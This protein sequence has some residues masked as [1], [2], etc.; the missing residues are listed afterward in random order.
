MKP[1]G[2]HSTPLHIPDSAEG[3]GPGWLHQAVSRRVPDLPPIE[4][5]R[6]E[7]IGADA[8]II[9]QLVRCHLDYGGESRGAPSTVIVK[10]PS[11]SASS[12]RMS[13]RFALY[14][15]EHLFYA[16]VADRVPVR[17]PDVFHADFDPRGQRFVLVLED[18]GG[19]PVVDEIEGANPL[20]AR[21][22]VRALARL[23]GRFWNRTGEPELAGA[24]DGTAR[25]LRST[26][27]VAYLAYLVRTL[28]TFGDAFTTTTR[29]IAEAYGPCVAY[30]M[31]VLGEPPRT[32]AHGDC[33]LDNLFFPRDDGG[34]LAFVDWQVSGKNSGLYDV[35]YFLGSGI[36]TDLR[37][38]IERDLV[39]EYHAGL[40][41]SGVSDLTF[42]ECWR[43]YRLNSFGRLLTMVLVCGGID[44][45]DERTRHLADLGL[46]R[47]LAQVED[48]DAEEFLPTRRRLFS[49]G[50]L[51]SR[52]SRM[53]Y[54]AAQ[55]R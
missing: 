44:L 33:R 3:I 51:F 31:A 12:R 15:R 23:H 5:I 47:S 39:A 40:V 8:G 37:R 52:A 11:L 24:Y 43:L 28:G 46:R 27:Q 21:Q 6:T 42:D 55:P 22:V 18:L 16:N 53:A 25:R 2:A 49:L 17:T 1:A 45:T 36:D 10:M 7:G 48:L 32:F 30:Y 26:A 19:M 29:R 50:G 34:D 14:Q 38:R 35:A 13:K 41:D 9:G 20:Q 54:K 4:S